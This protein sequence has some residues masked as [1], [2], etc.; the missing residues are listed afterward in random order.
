MEANLLEHF[1]ELPDPLVERTKLYPLNEI[2]L[3][4]IS[5]TVSGFERWKQKKILVK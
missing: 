5:A 2:I 4:I 3:L 1:S